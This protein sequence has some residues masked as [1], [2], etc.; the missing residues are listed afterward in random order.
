MLLNFMLSSG[1]ATPWFRTCEPGDMNG[2]GLRDT[3]RGTTPSGDTKG[4]EPEGRPEGRGAGFDPTFAEAVKRTEALEA[5]RGHV[6][7]L[8]VLGSFPTA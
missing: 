7:V 8:R 4:T 6:E 5:L 3:P 2:D 1:F